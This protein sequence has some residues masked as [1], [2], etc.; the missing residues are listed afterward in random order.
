M[1]L[2]VMNDLLLYRK[3]EQP[4]I[5]WFDSRGAANIILVA[6]HHSTRSNE[7]SSQ[8]LQFCPL[9]AIERFVLLS[10][11]AIVVHDFCQYSA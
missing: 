7:S 11:T 1:R 4:C 10:I 5:D 9:L 6:L 8:R 3:C 2:P